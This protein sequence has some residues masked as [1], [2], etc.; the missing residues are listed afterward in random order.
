MPLITSLW[1]KV[2]QYPWGLA[3]SIIIMISTIGWSIIITMIGNGYSMPNTK[4]S[5]G[6]IA[7]ISLRLSDSVGRILMLLILL[8]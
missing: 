5:Y 2:L 6:G 1:G 8:I 4:V 3:L 7:F